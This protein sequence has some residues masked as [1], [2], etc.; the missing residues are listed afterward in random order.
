MTVTTTYIA[1][2][3]R[4]FSNLAQ[5]RLSKILKAGYEV[6]RALGPSLYKAAVG[7]GTRYL[8]GFL[9]TRATRA[10]SRSDSMARG[11]IPWGGRSRGS[12]YAA[13]RT[14]RFKTGRKFIRPS[15]R[16]AGRR[17][18]KRRRFPRRRRISKRSSNKRGKRFVARNLPNRLQD[19]PKWHIYRRSLSLFPGGGG[20]VTNGQFFFD[21]PHGLSSDY[22]GLVA[23]MAAAK[24]NVTHFGAA[25]PAGGW[26]PYWPNGTLSVKKSYMMLFITNNSSTPVYAKMAVFRPRKH[27]NTANMQP[28]S[29]AD[30]DITNNGDRVTNEWDRMGTVSTLYPQTYPEYLGMTDDVE[31]GGLADIGMIWQQSPSFKRFYKGKIKNLKWAPMECK[32]FLFKKRGFGLDLATEYTMQPA[33]TNP[34]NYPVEWNAGTVPPTAYYVTP[35]QTGF[36]TM[37]QRRGF[38]VSFLAHGIPCSSDPTAQPTQ[39]TLT[40]PMFDMYYINAYKYGWS[41]HT[42]RETHFNA[43]P[44]SA[45][46]DPWMAI[47]MPGA[48][49]SGGV[50]LGN[51]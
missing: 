22:D 31:A 42:Y 7:H 46:L 30:V 10:L 40:A 33:T 8:S 25:P 2:A 3:C 16:R 15:N 32:K 20:G 5:F 43:N 12:Q 18:P 26:A 19:P 24:A 27:V 36:E 38:F 48:I 45:V 37:H 44:L 14:L 9:R 1:L 39:M 17:M 50:V 51:S 21:I 13:R 11:R 4:T 34:T 23:L 41:P 47:P 35:V 29:L 49:Q 6:A 28:S